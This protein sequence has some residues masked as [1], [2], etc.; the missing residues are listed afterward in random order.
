MTDSY[1][2]QSFVNISSGQELGIRDEEQV[3]TPSNGVQ[4]VDEID[5]SP[6]KARQLL[7]TN[8]I[9][10]DLA[11]NSD[12]IPRF[13]DK[14]ELRALDVKT[15]QATRIPGDE[16]YAVYLTTERCH[17][18]Y[19]P[20]QDKNAIR[21]LT[22]Y[23][24]EDNSHLMGKL[25]NVSIEC[26]T[27]YEALSYVWGDAGPG[28][29]TGGMLFVDQGNKEALLA[30]RGSSIVAALHQL[31]LPDRPRRIWTDQ[32]CINQDDP[33]E[34]SLQVQFMDRIYRNATHVLVWLGLD[35]QN[36]AALAFNLVR[37]LDTILA[38]PSTH[39]QCPD[40]QNTELVSH[41]ADN[42][43]ALQALASRTWFTRGWIVQEIGT[44][45]PATMYWG[46]SKLDW[47]MLASVCERL[48]GYHQLRSALGISTSNISFLYRRFMEPDEKTH[49][50]NRFNFVYELQRSRHLEFS[51]DRDRVFAFL[52]HFSLRS[53]HLLSCQPLSIAA[54]YT[55][56]V[57][58]TYI[59]VAVRILRQSPSS[60]CVLL[61]SVQHGS[62]TL[63]SKKA[64]K[65]TCRDVPPLNKDRIPSWVPDW[66][67][68]EGI[69][70]AEPICPHCAHADSVTE[71]DV[72]FEGSDVTLRITGLEI[73][74][75][76][77]CSR[78][79]AEADLYKQRVLDG[80]PTM[81]EQL[82]HDV[83]Q[84]KSFNLTD[85]YR[86]GQTDLFAFMQ[87]LANGC[88]Q[89]AGHK[90]V[91]YHQVPEGVWLRKAIRHIVDTLGESHHN[92]SQDI[93]SIAKD[94]EPDAEL[95]NWSR[96]ATSA[97][98][99]RIFARTSTGYY[100]LGPGVME[101]GDVVCVLLGCKVPFCL[102]PVGSRY[103][104]VGEC[105]VHGLMKG[106]AMAQLQQHELQTRAFDVI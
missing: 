33:V 37:E 12:A 34:R 30:L 66:R 88:V 65:A 9:V 64:G 90:S 56:T 21:I 73:D 63:P 48:K 35:A 92:I 52:G 97:S 46:N 40:G 84:R 41:V 68:A 57:R 7:D 60:T 49:H 53:R 89:A 95:E 91:P 54:D 67:H 80:R 27:S 81:M 98:D 3:P 105:Y 70:L 32:C 85:K 104:L 14:E 1:C 82:W 6:Q 69:I 5:T 72:V 10:E 24:G 2:F 62:D 25:E 20:L 74:A 38:S 44:N 11:S 19:Q 101:A 86:S 103:L 26:A 22:L 99:G 28:S 77:A 31:R 29:N 55:K 47:S 87:T 36:E 75:V 71:F 78:R 23:P 58:E 79:L 61:A 42:Y 93:Q 100:V 18:Q 45:A 96:W 15:C 102:R 59:D 94:I 43:K 50:A 13:F 106:E 51:D 4:D 76:E 16:Q 17:Y 39:D 83:C 8:K